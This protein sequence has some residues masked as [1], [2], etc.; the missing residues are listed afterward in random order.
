LAINHQDKPGIIGMLG[1]ICGR[2][3]INISFME[4]GRLTP[5]GKAVMLVGLDDLIEDHILDEIKSIPHVSSA[6]MIKL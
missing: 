2:H 1:T 4:V 5:R 6:I 3:D